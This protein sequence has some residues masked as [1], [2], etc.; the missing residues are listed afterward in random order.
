MAVVTED[1]VGP[2]DTLSPAGAALA[3]D[4]GKYSATQ[5]MIKARLPQLVKGA[6]YVGEGN[7]P[8]RDPVQI[9]T[10]SSQVALDL[11]EETMRGLT[12]KAS[13]V[14]SLNQGFLNQ[15]GYLRTALQQPSLMDI[16]GAVASPEVIRSF[17]A[18]NLGIGSV[19]GLVPFDLVRP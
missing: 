8:L 16:L 1:K 14:K 12:S 11:R 18:G 15:F 2:S 3:A 6:G 17:T 10:R 7:E 4:V 13:V 5:E 9:M 19:Y